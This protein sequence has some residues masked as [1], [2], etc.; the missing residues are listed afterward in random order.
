MLS[1]TTLQNDIKQIL[2]DF[3]SNKNI[4]T[5]TAIDNYSF[6]FSSAI[7]KYVRSIQVETTIVTLGS[8]TTQTGSGIGVIS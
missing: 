4:D 8:S 1:Q 7:D 3:Q 2:T 6:A 5:N